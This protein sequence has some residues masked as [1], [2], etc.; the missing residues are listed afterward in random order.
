MP[1]HDE[2]EKLASGKNSPFWQRIA[3][4]ERDHPGSVVG[5]GESLGP[6][7]DDLWTIL[8]EELGARIALG[9]LGKIDPTPGQLHATAYWLAEAVTWL[10][11]LQR[12]PT[13]DRRPRQ[14]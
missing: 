4:Y 3:D 8:T 5:Q 6:E 12:R 2:L 1:T 10:Y 7:G 11:T 13:A 9:Q 14:R